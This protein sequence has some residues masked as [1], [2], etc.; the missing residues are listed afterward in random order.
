M[1]KII[2]P[3]SYQQRR[4]RFRLVLISLILLLLLTFIISMNTGAGKLSPLETL[5]TLV[6]LGTARQNL[7]LFEFRLP[8]IVLS[9][10]VGI[11]LSL[12]G[13]IL[14]TVSRNALA[15][16]G[17]LGLNVGAGLAVMLFVSFV[18]PGALSTAVFMPLFALVGAA[19]TAVIIFGLS[20][21]R[22]E[23]LSPARLILTGI[24]MAAGINSAMIVL[25]L[26]LT[27]E[28]YQ[29]VAV[30]LAG[31][32]GVTS[33][34]Y[35]LALLPWLAVL[36]PFVFVKARVL[37]GLNF[38]D[39]LAMGLG[40]SIGR[41]RILLLSAAVILAGTSVS[42][43]GNIAFVG[44]IAPHLARQLVGSKHQY[45]LPVAALLGGLLVLAADTLG[46]Y[47]IEPSEIPA[48]IVVAIIGAPYFLYLLARAKA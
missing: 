9:V 4:R 45:Y 10:L 21:K 8:R 46:R 43:S 32:I 40:V 47:I 41:E 16:P 24:A 7:L 37:D 27:P 44:L 11:G 42:V 5:Q 36:V 19:L 30:W 17:I 1:E 35:V 48:G 38:G 2:L 14:Q 23:G 31:N 6:G 20:F 18:P 13:A 28:T 15:D 34:Q 33:W 39:Q 3:K 22:G 25:T 26:R 12:S 29:S